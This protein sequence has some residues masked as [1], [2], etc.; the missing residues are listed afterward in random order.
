[1]AFCF[2]VPDGGYD[3]WSCDLVELATAKRGDDISLKAALFVHV[4]HDPA[5]F[6]IAPKAESV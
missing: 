6:E 1:M 4:G 3:E 2:N 5:A